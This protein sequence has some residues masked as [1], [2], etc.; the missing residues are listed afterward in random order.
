MQKFKP[1]LINCLLCGN[2]VLWLY[3]LKKEVLSVSH[4]SGPN[5]VY[6]VSATLSIAGPLESTQCSS[7]EAIT[8]HSAALYKLTHTAFLFFCA[9]DMK[10]T[11][12]VYTEFLREK[13]QSSRSSKVSTQLSRSDL[14]EVLTL[15]IVHYI[16]VYLW[17]LVHSYLISHFVF[18]SLRFTLCIYLDWTMLEVLQSSMAGSSSIP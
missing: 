11:V 17:W 3:S 7:S 14:F 5:P 9:A 8:M 1:L 6:Y 16:L 13:L 2:S 4:I 10:E 18:Y 15:F 12:H